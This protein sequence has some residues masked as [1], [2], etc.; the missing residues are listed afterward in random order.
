[1]DHVA[2]PDAIADA[3]DAQAG[4][5]TPHVRAGSGGSLL[6]NGRFDSERIRDD[7]DACGAAPWPREF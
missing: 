4:A 7:T 2:A 1:M 3:F 5:G 6:A